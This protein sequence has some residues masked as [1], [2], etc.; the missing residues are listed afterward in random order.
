MAACQMTGQPLAADACAR[1]PGLPDP[2][3]PIKIVTP[4]TEDPYSFALSPNGE[5]LVY[6]AT[7]DGKN[8]LWMQA[9]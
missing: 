3:A 2:N 7:V 9:L 6:Q 1:I 4:F 5:T 8:L